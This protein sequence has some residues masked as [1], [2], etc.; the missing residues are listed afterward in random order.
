[1]QPLPASSSPKQLPDRPSPPTLG[2][3]ARRFPADRSLLR[4]YPFFAARGWLPKEESKSFA[5]CFCKTEGS[6]AEEA[7]GAGFEAMF[8]MGFEKEEEVFARG[9]PR[10][11][12]KINF[13]L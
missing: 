9:S 5:G 1:M 7:E 11:A 8:G 4:S 12:V 2:L 6:V 13:D 10:T 3:R